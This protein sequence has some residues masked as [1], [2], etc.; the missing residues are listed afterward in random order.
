MWHTWLW[1]FRTDFGLC[2]IQA[3]RFQNGLQLVS[4]PAV[5]FQNGLQ[6]MCHSWLYGFK[7]DFRLCDTAVCKVSEWP[8]A[9]VTQ[10]DVRCQGG[11]QLVW[12]SWLWG[13]RMDFGCEFLQWTSAWLAQLVVRFY[14][15][16][17][18]DTELAVRFQNWPAFF[19]Q[20]AVWF[21]NELS[22]HGT[23]RNVW[24]G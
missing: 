1:G 24:S 13:F 2:G 4:Q 19:V 8:R 20:L 16:L 22:L 14:I 3:V 9:C 11:L 6:L 18:C 17:L 7:M 10:L 23:D 12:Y 5:W 21:Q 15:G